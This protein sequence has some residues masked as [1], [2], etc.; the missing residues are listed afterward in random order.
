MVILSAMAYLSSAWFTPLSPRQTSL[1]RELQLVQNA[2][3][4]QVLGAFKDTPVPSVHTLAH[5]PPLDH[6]L[7]ERAVTASA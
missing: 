5:V 1:F 6:L 2:C 7:T 3:P 4:R